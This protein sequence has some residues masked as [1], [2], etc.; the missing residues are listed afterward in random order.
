ME[1]L[2]VLGLFELGVLGVVA[3]LHRRVDAFRDL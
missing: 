1:R 3:E 2:V